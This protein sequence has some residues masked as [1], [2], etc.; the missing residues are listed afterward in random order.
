MTDTLFPDLA[1]S[2]EERVKQIDLEIELLLW[3]KPGGALKLS[4]SDDEKRV[5]SL[6]R[7]RRGAA[8]A[9]TIAEMQRGM[10]G[11]AGDILSDR[12]IKQIVRTLRLNFRLPVGSN[13]GGM[14]GY[15]IMLSDEDHAILAAQILD[16]VRAEI[17]VLRAVS[18]PH[19]VLTLL[20]QLQL[21]INNAC[22][23]NS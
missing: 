19:A 20:G 14:G 22:P 16:Q 8:S 9:I 17:E 21:E 13:K 12:Q 7:Y 5:L 6:I 23:L 10:A 15:F 18:S 11:A 1:P 3:A 4:L 2:A